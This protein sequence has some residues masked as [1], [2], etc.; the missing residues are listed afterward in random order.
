MASTSP[1]KTIDQ[2]TFNLLVPQYSA[3]KNARESIKTILKTAGIQTPEER[4]GRPSFD[5]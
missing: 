3:L 5:K 4:E 2:N 1:L